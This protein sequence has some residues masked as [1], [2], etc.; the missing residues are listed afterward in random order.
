MFRRLMFAGLASG[1]A[2]T[3]IKKYKRTRT[4]RTQGYR[5]RFGGKRNYVAYSATQR[6][7][8]YKPRRRY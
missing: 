3:A 4:G 5:F 7:K 2:R 1:V 8:N 6:K